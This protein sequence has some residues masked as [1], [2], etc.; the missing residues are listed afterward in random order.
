MRRTRFLTV[1]FDGRATECIRGI[2]RFRPIQ[3]RHTT[4]ERSAGIQRLHQ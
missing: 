4:D 2:A 1:P 3:F